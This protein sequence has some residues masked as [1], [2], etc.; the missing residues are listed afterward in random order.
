MLFFSEYLLKE[1]SAVIPWEVTHRDRRGSVT[2]KIKGGDF[3]LNLSDYFRIIKL[4]NSY[5]VSLQFFLETTFIPLHHSL[6]LL[7]IAICCILHPMK[8]QT[9]NKPQILLSDL[10]QWRQHNIPITANSNQ[11]SQRRHR[12]AMPFSVWAVTRHRCGSCCYPTYSLGILFCGLDFNM[13][14]LE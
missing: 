14:F 9:L 5:F 10:A 4:W 1:M 8:V 7:L 12:Q 11:L 2:A 3:C 13:H 6:Y